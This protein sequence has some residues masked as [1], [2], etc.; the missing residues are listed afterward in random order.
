MNVILVSTDGDLYKLCREILSTFD[1]S[2]CHLA[3]ATPEDCPADADFYI[4][5]N[6]ARIDLPPGL[7]K[8]LS[9]YLFLVHRNEIATFY[10]NQGSAE[11]SILLKPVTRASLSAFLGL[12]ASAFQERICAATSLRAD[13]DEILQCLIQSNLKL[14]EYDQDRTNFLARAVHDFRAPLTAT[15]GYC[16]LLLSEALGQL[17]EDQKEIL[18][19]MQHSIKRLSRMASAM[20][21]LS[22]GRQVKKCPDFRKTDIR[23]C[24]EQALHEV[25]P[26]TDGKR[27]SISVDLD[28]A[29]G[30]LYVEPGQIEQVIINLLDNACK[31][32]PRAG[33][34]DIRGYPFFWERRSLDRSAT[35]VSERR[36]RNSLA[37]NAYRIDIRDSGPRIPREHLEN[38]FE[39]YTSYSGGQDRSGGGLGLAI[40]RMIIVLHDGRVWAENTDRG[41]QFSFV[42][43]TRSTESEISELLHTE[44]ANVGGG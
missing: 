41:P 14:Q 44:I 27:I 8:R 21:E 5:D 33:E 34:I 30:S 9:K 43:P 13:R 38:I 26:F 35:P 19:R 23:E 17:N 29:S 28:A 18:R 4:W 40:C 39:E 32:T 6:P 20:F 11:A 42:I 15:C 25:N 2:E 22:V 36:H 16:G 10:Q 31:F 24:V 37:V 12:A 3:P 7:D 1:G